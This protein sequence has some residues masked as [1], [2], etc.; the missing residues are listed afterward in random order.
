MKA[1]LG[2]RQDLHEL[3]FEE[4]DVEGQGDLVSSLNILYTWDSSSKARGFRWAHVSYSL[5]S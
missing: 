1:A 2:R 4:V 3:R 5:S